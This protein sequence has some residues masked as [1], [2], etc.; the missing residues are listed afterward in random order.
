MDITIHT[1]WGSRIEVRMQVVE[2]P[3][4]PTPLEPEIRRDPTVPEYSMALRALA[5]MDFEIAPT[6]APNLIPHPH[7]RS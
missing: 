6:S 2:E 3:L 5:K 1:A 7:S 4:F